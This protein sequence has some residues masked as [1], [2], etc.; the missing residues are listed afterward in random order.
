MRALVA[1]VA[2]VPGL[3][4]AQ[5]ASAPDLTA[6]ATEKLSWGPDQVGAW[7]LAVGCVLLW[8][9]GYQAGRSR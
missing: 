4:M 5:A 9:L 6:E 1:F 3:V 2:L 8:A 7:L